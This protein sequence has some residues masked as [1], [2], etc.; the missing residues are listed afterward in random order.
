MAYLAFK[1]FPTP[2]KPAQSDG[3]AAFHVDDG[4]QKSRSESAVSKQL[5]SSMNSNLES[6]RLRGTSTKLVEFGNTISGQDRG[7]S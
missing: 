3:M 5:L 4:L 6:F 7:Q 2:A 1:V